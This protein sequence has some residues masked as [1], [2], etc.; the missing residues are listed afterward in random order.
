MMVAYMGAGGQ[1][2]IVKKNTF[3]YRVST[4]TEYRTYI[5]PYRL[6][7]SFLQFP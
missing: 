5:E 4:S 2:N 6:F 7:D 1:K 3:F